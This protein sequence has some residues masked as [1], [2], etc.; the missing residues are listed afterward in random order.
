MKDPS[1]YTQ[2][3][4]IE[5]GFTLH[6]IAHLL[7]EPVTAENRLVPSRPVKLWPRS[8]VDEVRSREDIT[9]RLERRLAKKAARK[10]DR[11]YLGRCRELEEEKR[12]L[13]ERIREIDRE[14]ETLRMEPP[15]RFEEDRPEARPSG[16]KGNH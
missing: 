6:E 10:A 1:S 8:V 13:A 9:A 11:Q 5:M 12:I 16:Q 3:D 7:P 2:R 15:P 4:L 14:L